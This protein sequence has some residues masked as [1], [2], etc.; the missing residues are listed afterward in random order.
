MDDEGKEMKVK[1]RNQTKWYIDWLD[2]IRH[3]AVVKDGFRDSIHF[4]RVEAL[5]R[6]KELENEDKRDDN[7]V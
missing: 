4:T 7:N 6:I 2:D 3:Y 1:T 5:Q